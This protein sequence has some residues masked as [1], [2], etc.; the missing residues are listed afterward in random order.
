MIGLIMA[1][2]PKYLPIQ[3]L[4]R[5]AAVLSIIA[6]IYF[7]GISTYA[8]IITPDYSVISQA[9]SV[10]A[11][12]GMPNAVLMTTGFLGYALMIQTLG[13]LLFINTDHKSLGFVI[14]VLVFI[15]GVS[16]IFASIYIDAGTQETIWKLSEGSRQDLASRI[17]FFAILIVIILSIKAINKNINTPLWKLF[18]IAIAILTIVFAIS[19]GFRLFPNLIGLM[20]RGFFITIMLWIFVTT[21]ICILTNVN[22]N[23]K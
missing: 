5:Y 1:K 18:S 16:G 7:I 13:P 12:H 2:V 23:K 20:Q 19:F 11:R 17:G 10:L 8:S 9:Y 21:A 15:Y 14:C 4:I 22:E 3:S 6:P